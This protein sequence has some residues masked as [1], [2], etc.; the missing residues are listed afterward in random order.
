MTHG[1][2]DQPDRR[3]RSH[4]SVEGGYTPT[5]RAVG[6]MGMD[7][8]DVRTTDNRLLVV[9]DDDG[10]RRVVAAILEDEGY[11]VLTASDAD[12]AL[13]VLTDHAVALVVSDVKMPSR[14]GLWL[15]RQIRPMYVDTAVILLTG[16][17]EV[18]SAVE[19]LK[20][21]AYDYLR[22][23]VRVNELSAAVVKALDRRRLQRE[24][25]AYQTHLEDMVK[26]KTQ[27]LG[28]AYDRTL[29]ALVTA[30]DA[31]ECETGN[32]SQRVVRVTL[33]IC[34]RMGITGDVRANIAR[35]ALLHDIGKIGVPDQVLLKPGKLTDAEWVEMRKH[36]DIG[37]RILSGIDFLNEAAD[38]VRAHQERYDGTGYPQ[39]L[40]GEAIPVG[41]RIFAVADALDAIVSDRPY[42]RGQSLD[43]A[44]KEIAEGAGTQFDP[45]VVEAFLSLSDE[46]I[47]RVRKQPSPVRAL[48]READPPN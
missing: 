47:L 44:R 31:R 35:G 21:G 42:R 1:L 7:D 23:P 26:A 40:A 41:A 25:R 10:V 19:A 11:E 32:H 9:D 48:P 6:V 45:Q 28:E 4:L 8:L 14:D 37:A 22:K 13:S 36:P 30:L 43:H 39:G 16:Y 20:E 15:L 17:G 34:D 27:E 18:D 38:I 46:E 33:A 2:S 12:E 29:E 5:S 24:N 3:E